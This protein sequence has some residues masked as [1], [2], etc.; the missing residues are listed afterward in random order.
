[1]II[2]IYNIISKP[3]QSRV[4]LCGRCEAYSDSTARK[5]QLKIVK[6][7]NRKSLGKKKKKGCSLQKKGF[8]SGMKERVGDEKLIKPYLIL[9]S[10]ALYRPVPSI[11]VWILIRVVGC[12]D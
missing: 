8:K 9:Q 10:N 2:R 7:P 5:R 4:Q 1:V 3:V 12:Y 6:Q 11:A